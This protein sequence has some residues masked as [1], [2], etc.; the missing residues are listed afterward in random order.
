MIV[1]KQFYKG[2][3]FLLA[4]LN[5]SLLMQGWLFKFMQLHGSC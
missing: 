5:E 4:S 2:R 3:L 1:E